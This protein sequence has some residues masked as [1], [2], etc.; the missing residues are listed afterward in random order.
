MIDIVD[1]VL[2]DKHEHFLEVVVER[3]NE[4][5]QRG[6]SPEAFVQLDD[7]TQTDGNVLVI[8]HAQRIH[9]DAHDIGSVRFDGL[10]DRYT[11]KHF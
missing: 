4:L 7:D 9:H 11:L 8:V 6:H 10:T 5:F 3:L 1:N 2:L